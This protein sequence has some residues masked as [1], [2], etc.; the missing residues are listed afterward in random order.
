MSTVVRTEYDSWCDVVVHGRPQP[1]GPLSQT[2]ISTL[3]TR[4][5][6]GASRGLF[7]RI[8]DG[9]RE[10]LA[11][12]R[13]AEEVYETRSD[14]ITTGDSPLWAQEVDPDFEYAL[15]LVAISQGDHRSAVTHLRSIEYPD[16]GHFELEEYYVVLASSLI[17]LGDADAALSA[18]FEYADAEM[19]V[20]A[21]PFL[22]RSL[23]LLGALSGF[24]IMEDEIAEAAVDHYLDHVDLSEAAPHAV[25]IKVFYLKASQRRGD[26]DE[27][28]ESA[29][30]ANPDVDWESLGGGQ[31]AE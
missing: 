21:I 11:P 12:A 4:R 16:L 13:E 24:V 8:I 22:P 27:L 15:A 30:A 9:V 26:A 20:S 23:Q 7:R 25:M 14:S 29:R 31:D 17:E 6:R 10:F 28:L 19:A 5:D 18:V 1:I 2:R 3:I